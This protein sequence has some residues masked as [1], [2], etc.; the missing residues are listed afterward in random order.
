MCE[1]RTVERGKLEKPEPCTPRQVSRICDE[2][3][4]YYAQMDFEKAPPLPNPVPER[5]R[6]PFTRSPSVH[7]PNDSAP[8]RQSTRVSL[9]RN[10][11]RNV[12]KFAL[13]KA[14]QLV[15]WRKLTFD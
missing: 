10:F 4:A 3:S 12:T 11:D 13:H 14:P 1:V 9:G 15:T 6:L 7:G 2:G 8:T 5:M